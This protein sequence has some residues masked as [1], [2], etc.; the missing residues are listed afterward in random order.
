M[1][2][3]QRLL[4]LSDSGLI[5]IAMQ[6]GYQSEAAFSKAFKRFAGISPGAYKKQ[7]RQML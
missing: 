3:A 2:K 5:D 1:L 7:Q 4:P 6:V